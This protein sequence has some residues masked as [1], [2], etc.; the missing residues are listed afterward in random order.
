MPMGKRNKSWITY[1][2]FKYKCGLD[3]GIMN[4]NSLEC[5]Y[6]SII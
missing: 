5:C 1:I 4:N 6:G 2:I 3:C